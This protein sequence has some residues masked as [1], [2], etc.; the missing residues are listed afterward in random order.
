[1]QRRNSRGEIRTSLSKTI[2]KEIKA[3]KRAKAEADID[4][5]LSDRRGLKQLLTCSKNRNKHLVPYMVDSGGRKCTDRQGIADVFCDFYEKLYTSRISS[6]T[7]IAQS[8]SITSTAS[9]YIPPFQR[10]ELV[11]ELAKLKNGR[12]ADSAGI[13][14]EFLKYGGP[15]VVDILLSTFNEVL[16]KIPSTPGTWKKTLVTVIF[17]KGSPELPENYRPISIIPILYKLFSRLLYTRLY[18]I[19]D[20]HQSEDQAGFRKKYGNTTSS[21]NFCIYTGKKLRVANSSLGCSN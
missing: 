18:A 19:L 4:R 15:S 1:M 9:T 14:A 3:I 17:K 21:T 11:A 5:I 10:A 7:Y 20:K 6:D 12:A 13:C 2:Q 8:G 16:L